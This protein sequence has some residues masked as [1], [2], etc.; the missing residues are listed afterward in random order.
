MPLNDSHDQLR[1]NKIK[2]NN[3]EAFR[4][5]RERVFSLLIAQMDSLN[6]EP[7]EISGA[8]N[9]YGAP[10]YIG[11]RRYNVLVEDTNRTGYAIGLFRAGNEPG[12]DVKL[13][14]WCVLE[15]EAEKLVCCDCAFLIGR[16]T[17]N[18]IPIRQDRFFSLMPGVL[19]DEQYYIN[20][21]ISLDDRQNSQTIIDCTTLN[22]NERLGFGSELVR[23]AILL[24]QITGKSQ[25]EFQFCSSDCR[26][27]LKS[28]SN[29]FK[30]YSS[31][32]VNYTLDVT[33]NC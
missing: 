7:I 29:A 31:D 4:I 23:H 6:A 18:G 26:A 21:G 3:N 1:H 11:L 17:V 25:L 27:M 14:G 2:A 28:T 15:D 24:A 8:L 13:F 22:R 9:G 20:K 33:S 30:Y 10:V 12:E 32:M 19:V 5:S 16:P